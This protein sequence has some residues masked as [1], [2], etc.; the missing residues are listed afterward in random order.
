MAISPHISRTLNPTEHPTVAF[1]LTARWQF[2][3]LALAAAV[4]FLGAIRLGDLAGYDDALYSLQAKG[5]VHTGDWLTPKRAGGPALEHPP[6]FVWTQA[7][8]FSVFGVSDF[9]AKLPTALCAIGTVLLCYWLARKLL[10]DNLAAAVAMFV[11]LATPYFIKYAGRAMTDVPTT[12]LFV[13]AIC[14][15]SRAEEHSR[16]VLIA[17][18]STA[19]AL[20]VRDL[21]G[22]AL[23]VIF[24]IDLIARRRGRIQTSRIKWP[25]LIAAFA[26]ALLPVASWY[27]YLFLR[28][29][30]SFLSGNGVFLGQVLLRPLNPP[31]RS[32]TGAPEYAWMLLKSYWPWLPATVAGMAVICRGE[33]MDN[34]GEILDKNMDKNVDNVD[35]NTGPS[36]SLFILLAWIFTVI[37]MCSAARS[38]VLRY[39]LPAYPAFSILA[40]I[41][42][43]TWAP[44]R[45]LDRAMNWIPPL[46]VAASATIVLFWP[47]GWHATEMRAITTVHDRV[48]PSSQ[49]VGF[50]DKG[51]PR[52]DETNQMEW[53]GSQIPVDLTA[54]TLDEALRT[55]SLRV[56]VVDRATYQ[57]RLQQLPHEV[58]VESGHLVSVRLTR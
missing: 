25:W 3:L 8:F 4:L 2:L 40:A 1:H 23:P 30:S 38:R 54:D 45:I 31:W 11:M 52:Y 20:M 42:L 13:C 19:A 15:W 24:A 32:Y 9:V 37:L 43:I 49:L 22:L 17:G 5:I 57:Q 58:L 34:R 33:S 16:W 55:N 51:D 35:Q 10:K 27:T 56:L 48:L 36:R 41:G 44:R 18:L 6:L 46:A 26:I 21:I 50:Y 29:R 47:P 28:Y 14:A 7:F 12:F 53:Y 39:M